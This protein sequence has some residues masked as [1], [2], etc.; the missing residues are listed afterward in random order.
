MFYHSMTCR[1]SPLK[2]PFQGWPPAVRVACRRLTTQCHIGPFQTIMQ[3]WEWVSGVSQTHS[4]W[5]VHTEGV[6]WHG[7]LTIRV[8]LD[9]VNARWLGEGL[10][11][12]GECTVWA[13]HDMVSTCC[14]CDMTWWGW[15][16]V[17]KVCAWWGCCVVDVVS[18][19]CI[20]RMVWAL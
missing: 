18:G 20:V 2:Q 1:R 3:A 11:R 8:W 7:M 13:W 17:W 4:A 14:W 5:R 15:V 6:A 16:L 10:A 12:P 9:I 19:D